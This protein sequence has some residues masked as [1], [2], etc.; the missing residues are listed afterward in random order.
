MSLA[1]ASAGMRY[2]L[3]MSNHDISVAFSDQKSMF[4]SKK[5]VEKPRLLAQSSPLQC[6]AVE[7]TAPAHIPEGNGSK[8]GKGLSPNFPSPGH[9]EPCCGDVEGLA[10][11]TR[12]SCRR[13]CPAQ[14]GSP[15]RGDDRH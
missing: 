11:V 8:N 10:F 15:V 7:A 3:G 6:A 12:S 1:C 4:L 9:L 13:S 2:G 14:Q 5:N